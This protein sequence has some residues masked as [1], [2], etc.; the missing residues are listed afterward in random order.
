MAFGNCAMLMAI[1]TSPRQLH[2][3]II[4]AYAPSECAWS[5]HMLQSDDET[6]NHI[7]RVLM[8]G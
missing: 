1:L 4:I 3:A 7:L 8:E 2:T 5:Q 6:P